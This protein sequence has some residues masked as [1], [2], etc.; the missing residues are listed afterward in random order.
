MLQGTELLQ[1]RQSDPGRRM[2]EKGR[3]DEAKEEVRTRGSEAASG[4][5]GKQ[6]ERDLFE[7]I[8]RISRC[9]LLTG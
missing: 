7:F 9:V 3:S 8:G 2:A 1:K 5:S 4:R 6:S